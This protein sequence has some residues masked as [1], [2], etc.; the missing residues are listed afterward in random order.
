MLPAKQ[1]ALW[2]FALSGLDREQPVLLLYVVESKGSSPGRQGFFMV[3]NGAGEKEGSVGGG[4]MEHKFFE[5]AR[6]YLRQNTPV[7]MLRRQVHDKETA[8]DQSGMICSGEQTIL[9]L[10]LQAKDKPAIQ[11][12]LDQQDNGTLQFTPQGMTVGADPPDT[13]FYFQQTTGTEWLYREKTGYTTRLYII[14]GGHV[15]LAFSRLM[16]MMDFHI[17]L[18]DDRSG[19][20]SFH[21][22]EYV[23]EKRLIENYSQLEQYITGGPNIFVVVMTQGYRTDDQAIRALWQKEFRYFG[24]LGSKAKVE[25][26]LSDYRLEGI[27]EERLGK[28]R[29]PAGLAIHSQTPEEIAVSI[30]AEIIR[31]KHASG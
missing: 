23:Q 15:A 21:R 5:L 3:V 6:E 17:T 30:A 24:V 14:G 7:N 13:D 9:L 10:S 20:D 1:S 18:F 26:L 25:K 22:N 28:L 2:R 27:S 8:K 12:L 29:A 31:H 4:I 16:Q 11:R 19:L